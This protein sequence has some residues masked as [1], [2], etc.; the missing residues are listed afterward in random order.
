[1]TKDIFDKDLNSYLE[2]EDQKKCKQCGAPIQQ[3]KEFCSKACWE[4]Y[5]E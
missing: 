3:D 5:M 1:M 2:D 4:Y